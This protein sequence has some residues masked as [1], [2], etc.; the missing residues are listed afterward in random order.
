MVRWARRGGGQAR[1]AVRTDRPRWPSGAR[2]FVQNGTSILLSGVRAQR[3]PPTPAELSRVVALLAKAVGEDAFGRR[4]G[5]DQRV[6]HERLH[7]FRV[8][9]NAAEPGWFCTLIFL[10]P[11]LDASSNFLKR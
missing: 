11:P 1:S 7:A 3:P 9:P 5:P 4:V 8:L 6:G 10:V 2:S